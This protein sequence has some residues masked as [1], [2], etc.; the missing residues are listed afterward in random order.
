VDEGEENPYPVFLDSSI[1]RSP[2]PRTF[3]DLS[4]AVR[5]LLANWNTETQHDGDLLVDNPDF[6]V[7]NDLL[8]NRRPLAGA[9][10][11]D[12]TN[13]ATYQADPNTIRDFDAT[14]KPWPEV[15]AQLLGF[16]GFGMRWVCE[17]DQY[18]QPYNYLE[19]YRK[20]AAGP[21]SPKQVYLPPTGSDL[22]TALTNVAAMHAAYDYHAVAN[23]IFVE[24]SPERFEIA[25]ILAPGYT[26]TAGDELPANVTQFRLSN[27][28]ASDANAT[29][30]AKYR[31]YIADECGDGHWSLARSVWQTDPFDFTALLELAADEKG[32]SAQTRYVR[33]YRPGA[34]WLFSHDL[35]NKPLPAQLAISRDY[36]GA[37]PPCMW[38][39][40]SGTWQTIDGG[41]RLMH[42][43]L[44]IEVTAEDPDQWNI[45]KPL[46]GSTAQEPTGVLHGIASMSNP[47]ALVEGQPY[48]SQQFW[49]R[50]TTVI[51][52]DHGIE[53]TA[54]RR[55][56]SP[57]PQTITR[58]VDARDHFYYDVVDGSSPFSK[59]PGPSG[60]DNSLV[61]QDD[62]QS[63]LAHAC[64]IRAARELPPLAAAVTIPMLINYIQIGDRID[65]INGREVSLLTNAGIEQGEAPAYPFVVAVTWDFQGDQ[66]ATTLQLSDRRLEPRRI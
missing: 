63:A 9:A 25:V 48:T 52:A 15:I 35:N 10:F 30:R 50:L 55:D 32:A 4:K 6:S 33:R 43:R 29:T 40:A 7:L 19:V 66:Q 3:W 11:F 34:N 24:S 60:P 23:E 49:L 57:L 20:D 62:S 21:T 1:D 36:N 44:G 58:R 28:E 17:D 45:G 2:D 61:V 41:W 8:Q 46:P 37:D 59:T 12:P 5:Y 31:Y 51:E 26:P 27:L 14:N 64:Q 47:A 42:D 54:S 56:A 38:D 65:K 39:S 16:Y 13:P 53:T 22:A 18:G